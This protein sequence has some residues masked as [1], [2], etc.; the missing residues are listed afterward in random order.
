MIVLLEGTSL[1]PKIGTHTQKIPPITS[2]NDNK[3]NSAAGIA[4]E[5]IEYKIKPRQTSVPCNENIALLQ[6]VEKKTRSFVKITIVAKIIQKKPAN[7]TVVNFGVSFLHLKVTE[8]TEN[9]IEDV[10]PNTNPINEFCSLL[11]MAIIVI[12]TDAI[13]I[14]IQ[15]FKEIVSL[16]NKKANK[17][18][19]KG[20]AAKHNKVIAAL[21][22]VIE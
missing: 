2:V 15:T 8:K 13:I 14:D 5:P 12:P 10:I 6:L 18:V 7:A 4:F 17:A 11:P 19:K 22:L 3:V 20:I 9:P 21:V 1:I 16:R